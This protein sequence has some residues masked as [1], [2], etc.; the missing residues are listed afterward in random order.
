M[1]SPAFRAADFASSNCAWYG[2]WLLLLSVIVHWTM[3]VDPKYSQSSFTSP[4]ET[5]YIMLC[6]SKSNASIS[7]FTEPII[8]IFCCCMFW[9]R[10]GFFCRDGNMSLTSLKNFPEFLRNDIIIQY[11][12]TKCYYTRVNTKTIFFEVRYGTILRTTNSF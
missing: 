12:L 10:L 3:I 11:V 9:L 2:D 5:C 4:A 7:L 8:I 6:L 1:I